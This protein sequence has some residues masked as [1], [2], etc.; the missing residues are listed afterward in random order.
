M[1]IERSPAEIQTLAHWKLIG[2]IMTFRPRVLSPNSIL[3]PPSIHC[4]FLSQGKV[5]VRFKNVI[6][7]RG[8]G[9]SGWSTPR[10][11][12]FTP[13][14]RPGAHCIGG[15]VG[16]RPALEGCAKSRHPPEFDPQTVQSL[17]SRYFLF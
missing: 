16:P 6:S 14:E 8:K 11:G 1:Y 3:P 9:R 13:R 5:G 10:L 7:C 12:R 2:R 4:A 15:W 17:A